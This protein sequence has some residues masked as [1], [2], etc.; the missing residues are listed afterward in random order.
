MKKQKPKI[1]GHT[2]NSLQVA[3]VIELVEILRL[4]YLQ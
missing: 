3:M 4:K 1:F 2:P